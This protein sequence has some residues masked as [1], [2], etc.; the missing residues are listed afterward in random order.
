MRNTNIFLEVDDL[1]YNLVVAP[2][3]KNKTFTKLIKALLKSY[4][5]DPYVRASAEGT[6]D[7]LRQQS[8]DSLDSAISGITASLSNMGLYTDELGLTASKG[9]N[10]FAKKASQ[11]A[12]STGSDTKETVNQELG[13]EN[14]RLRNEVDSL[15]QTVDTI[16]KQ[17]SDILEMLKN[18]VSSKEPAQESTL[19][20]TE[21][22]S[23]RASKVV[24]IPKP[25]VEEEPDDV[26]KEVAIT[27]EEVE[28]REEEETPKA[29]KSAMAAFMMGNF[30]SF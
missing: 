8:V 14:D 28:E 23:S 18:F 26:E 10:M 15:K 30:K 16:S 9:K 7:E 24:S 4:M 6:L 29:D 1:T 25:V 12:E 20:A 11:Y 19:G 5:E 3:K 17:N 13:K 21:D 2:H 27:T 22:V